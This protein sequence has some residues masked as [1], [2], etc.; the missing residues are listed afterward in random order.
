MILRQ[1]ALICLLCFSNTVYAQIE[2]PYGVLTPTDADLKNLAWNR[3]TTENFA[4]LSIDDEQGRWLAHNIEHIKKWCLTRWGFPENSRHLFTKECRVF[5][6]PDKI[7]MKKL[8]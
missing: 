8:F 5:C 2:H 1:A 7:L 4:I 6:V 3:Y